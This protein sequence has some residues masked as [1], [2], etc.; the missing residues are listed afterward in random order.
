MAS[1]LVNRIMALS[2]FVVLVGFV[3]ILVGYVP[4]W[5][6]GIMVA[7]TVALAGWDLWHV[8]TGRKEDTH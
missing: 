5:D 2:A 1:N 8:A 6:L 4:R 3:G 7:F